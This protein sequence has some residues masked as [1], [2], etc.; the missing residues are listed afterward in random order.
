MNRKIL[1]IEPNYKNKFP[2]IGLM[3][4]STYF[5]SKGDDVYF[6][7]GKFKDFILD[8]VM[9]AL[10]SKLKEINP[11]VKWWK[12]YDT[13]RAYI[14]TRKS[15]HLD[16]IK[17]SGLEETELAI[18]WGNHFKNYFW[19]KE[20][21]K[22][23]HKE[24]D[25]IIVTT[26][27]TF[28]FEI[29]VKTINEFKQLLKKDGQIMVGG[30]LATLQPDAIE[31]A[32]AIR[33]FTGIMNR[34][35]LIDADDEQ[36]IDTLPLDYSILEEIDF[37][38]DS[39]N[40]YYG[41][42]SKGCIRHCAFCAVPK[43]EPLY[44]NF[45][46]MLPRIKRVNEIYGS[47]RDL[48]LMDNNVLAS[49]RFDEI[50]EDIIACGFERGSI[51]EEPNQLDVAINNLEKGVNDRAYLRKAQRELMA[52]YKSIPESDVQRSSNI[53]TILDDH[54]ML[55]ISTATKLEALKAYEALR[56]EYQAY[57]SKKRHKARIVDF[58]QGVDARLFTP[59]IAEQ[60]GRIAIS[61]LRIAFDNLEIKEAYLNAIKLSAKAGIRS[62]SNYLLYNF[63]DRPEELYER[64][65]INIKLCTSEGI[66]I[67]S[68]PMKFH[69]IY[70][71]FSHNRDYIGKYWNRKYIRA[72]QAILNSTKGCIGRGEQFFYKAFGRNIQEFKTLLEMPDTML[73][74]RFFFE[75][76]GEKGHPLSIKNWVKAVNAL[77]KRDQDLFFSI[78][79]NKH[80]TTPVILEEYSKKLKEV[81]AFYHNLRDEIMDENGSLHALKLEF[82]ALPKEKASKYKSTFPG[83]LKI[84]E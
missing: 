29:T 43:L 67:Y 32:T 72:V 30:V 80:F 50:I 77:G 20:Y 36:I 78:I 49:S 84:Y 63:N 12:Y 23:E 40:A 76:L 37:R 56:E 59:H 62:F 79:H 66:N 65:K 28:Y 74:Y 47:Q 26:L 22:D 54:G 3:K 34:P 58:N 14:K 52:F 1:L 42:T 16:Q 71:D 6:F 24:W 60:L 17:S 53:F 55:S 31:Q 39:N 75:W 35:G 41:S 8:R 51:Y 73:I 4:L 19:K 13:L 68:F 82:N 2:P 7:K 11:S 33:P 64:L 44:E 38:Y 18:D 5:K 25:W 46:P 48:L 15:Q 70:G 21:L 61:P 9:D 57:H 83:I 69:P 27:F 10:M 81:L 45:T